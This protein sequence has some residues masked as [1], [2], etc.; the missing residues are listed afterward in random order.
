MS[1]LGEFIFSHFGH[2]KAAK[3]LFYEFRPR[4]TTRKTQQSL[5]PTKRKNKKIIKTMKLA[6]ITFSAFAMMA[7]QQASAA[8]IIQENFAYTAGNL[9][10]ATAT[11]TGLSGTW[12]S[13]VSAG[14]ATFT[15][16]ASS[17][18]F[19]GHFASS[20]G[21]LTASSGDPGEKRAGTAVTG[22]IPANSTF[23][24]SSLMTMNTAGAYFN[25]WVVEQRFNTTNV[26]SGSSSGRNLLS[27][28]G[29]GT[30]A[31]RRAGVSV[32]GGEVLTAAGVTT[33]GTNY[34]LVTAYTSNATNVTSAT[35]YGFTVADYTAYL[36]NSTAL[37]AAANLAT[38]RTFSVSETAGQTRPLGDFDFLQ[39]VINGGPTAQFDDFR[40][41]TE[42]TD[43]VNIPEPAA[44]LLGGLGLLSLL[45][46]RR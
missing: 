7:L 36:A 21:S 32:N 14:S 40:L 45:R 31:S 28:F 19:A 34:L 23:Y 20:G 6:K 15:V 27:G 10:G 17:L 26:D 41:G 11:G 43:V 22:A 8:L 16:Q 30:T 9:I 42:I 25:D 35:M 2:L 38:Y 29:S 1:L 12:A 5:T 13:S 18:A 39:Y 33:A 44:A 4:L 3:G 37:N 46:R 24:T